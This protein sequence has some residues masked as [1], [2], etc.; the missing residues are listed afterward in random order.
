MQYDITSKVLFERCKHS[1]LK[2]LCRLDFI[3]IEEIVELPQETVSLRRSD[4]VVKVKTEN[5]KLI[6]I[7][8]EFVRRWEK[9][10]PLRTLEYR[11]R[12]KIKEDLPVITIIIVLLRGG[13]VREEYED[14]EVRYRYILV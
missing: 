6:I 4:F 3:E 7:I 14:E 10:L 13:E 1:L 12:Y 2:L 9:P 5:K 11:C 8:I